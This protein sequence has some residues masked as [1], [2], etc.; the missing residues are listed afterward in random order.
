MHLTHGGLRGPLPPPSPI[1]SPA[2]IGDPS[3]PGLV[4]RARAP[5]ADRIPP[6]RS[7]TLGVS[8]TSQDELPGGLREGVQ[9]ARAG[10]N[11]DPIGP[12]AAR[13]A[14]AA[15]RTPLVR[16]STCRTRALGSIPSN[17]CRVRNNPC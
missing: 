11:G 3:P 13:A 6:T 4:A 2:T 1:V 16:I 12:G 10:R 14:T 17:S 8:Q 5:C 9:A 7:G 15:Q